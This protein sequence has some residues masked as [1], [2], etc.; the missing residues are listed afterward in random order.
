[1]VSVMTDVS[2]PIPYQSSCSPSINNGSCSSSS[3]CSCATLAEGGNICTQQMY[4][5]YATPCDTNDVCDKVN[6]TCVIDPRCPNQSLCY[7]IDIFSPELCPPPVSTWT[8]GN[9]RN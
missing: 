4:C 2:G 1:M 6:S 7:E 9:N 8:D 3:Y 5:E